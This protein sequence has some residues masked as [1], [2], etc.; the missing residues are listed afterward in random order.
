MLPR[1]SLLIIAS[2]LFASAWTSDS[3]FQ[4]QHGAK[5]AQVS[6]A[7]THPVRQRWLTGTGAY[8]FDHTTIAERSHDFR[9]CFDPA[10]HIAGIV[11]HQNF[12][13][14]PASAR[15][16]DEI[17]MDSLWTFGDT[18]VT[19]PRDIVEGT[20]RA[21]NNRGEVRIMELNEEKLA[22]HGIL[23]GAPRRDLYVMDDE[24]G[25]WYFIRQLPTP[26][27]ELARKS[28]NV[29]RDR[30]PSPSESVE[31]ILD[32]V[33][34]RLIGTAGAQT[35][36]TVAFTRGWARATWQH[37]TTDWIALLRQTRS[38]SEQTIDWIHAPF[39]NVEPPSRM[40]TRPVWDAVN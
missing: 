34:A 28:T 14:S 30:S 10:A 5:S 18:D 31:S 27:M 40:A 29:K 39:D 4:G 37:F 12:I 9:G 2:L 38:W 36:E 17:P 16:D 24:N 8:G 20:Y 23:A 11:R 35:A 15:T 19:L 1:M 3:Q 7:P 13:G 6:N 26:R 33:M 21:V 22:Y 32:L 25:R